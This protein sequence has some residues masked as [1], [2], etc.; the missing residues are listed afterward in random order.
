M[1]KRTLISFAIAALAQ[2]A[3]AD[4]LS[5]DFDATLSAGLGHSWYHAGGDNFNK[6]NYEG[7][8]SVAYTDKSGWGGQADGVY[9]KLNFGDAFFGNGSFAMTDLAGHLYYRNAGW[10]LGVLGQ[11]RNFDTSSGENVTLPLHRNFWGVEGQKYFDQV[12]LYGQIG[13]QN[14]S[15]FGSSFGGD[16][17]TAKIR[18]FIDDNWRV[19]GRLGYSKFSSG[20]PPK[21]WDYGIG[22]EYHFKNTPFSLFAEYD[23]KR[24]TGDSD[25]PKADVLMLGVKLDIGKDSLKKRDREGQTLDPVPLD[26]SVLGF[27]GLPD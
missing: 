2:A 24:P 25:A 26:L 27:L 7:R 21:A 13:R 1:F 3:V 17:A 5:G 12:T 20:H 11:R 9:S 19:D 22:T 15:V 23:Y 16:F 6:D 14:F 4:P 10:L 18:Y 8:L